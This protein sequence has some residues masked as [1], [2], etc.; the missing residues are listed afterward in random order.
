M[1]K[2]FHFALLFI[3]LY[4]IYPSPNHPR[5]L[6]VCIYCLLLIFFNFSISYSCV[7]LS[8]IELYMWIY[9]RFNKDLITHLPVFMSRTALN[10]YKGLTIKCYLF[11]YNLTQT[12]KWRI[13]MYYIKLCF[14]DMASNA[15]FKSW[16]S[17][18]LKWFK[19]ECCF[20]LSQS[21]YMRGKYLYI[22]TGKPT[23]A[24]R[25]RNVKTIAAEVKV[26]VKA[27][28][29][30]EFK[31]F[32]NMKNTKAQKRWKMIFFSFFLTH[33]NWFM[34]IILCWYQFTWTNV[35]NK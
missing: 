20:F 23:I 34:A 28:V 31:A 24:R 11:R 2:T 1:A 4:F 22:Y 12:N 18:W 29:K 32:T 5:T 21:L 6:F 30:G 14:S 35:W 3:V 7:G 8:Y 17:Y 25:V 26:R 27:E 33:N 19:F 15:F 13:N 9:V 16:H 10:R